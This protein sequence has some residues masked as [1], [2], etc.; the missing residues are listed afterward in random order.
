VVGAPKADFG[1]WS[2]GHD[3]GRVLLVG[4]DEDGNK[5]RLRRC[6]K[7]GERWVTEERRLARAVTFSQ[8]LEGLKLESAEKAAGA[9]G[10]N[11]G[12]AD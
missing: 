12:A 11:A 3:T 1:C 4:R 7:C 2:C 8:R 9:A 6:V 5:I 10:A